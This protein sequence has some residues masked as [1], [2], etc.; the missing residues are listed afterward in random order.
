MPA[1]YRAVADKVRTGEY[2]RESRSMYDTMVHDPMTDRYFFIF[3]TVLSLLGLIV[4]FI[5]MRMLYPLQVSVPF[6]YQAQNLAEDMPYIKTLLA[7][8]GE[9]PGEALLRFLVQN[10]V[11]AREEYDIAAF[12]RDVSGVSAQSDKTV[13]NEY[14]HAVDPANPE[15]PLALYQRHSKRRID[16]ISS[17]RLDGDFGMEVLYEATVIS[18]TE[19]KKSRWQADIAFQYGGLALDEDT[20]KAK[21][22]DFI[23]T[24]Y[25]TKRLQDTK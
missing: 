23:V 6:A 21:P 24:D 15:S 16:I 20:G 5:G 11:V 25:R 2:F 8:K 3:L 14:R 22:I 4:A 12:D 13:L 7:H 17:R 10:Y 9:D 18:K 1:D 19:A